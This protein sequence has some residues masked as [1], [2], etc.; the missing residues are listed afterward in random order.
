MTTTWPEVLGDLLAKRDLSAD[1]ARW[2][3]DQV[4][5]GEA[6][7]AQIAGFVIA[8]RAKGETAAEVS[9]LVAAMLEAAVT[10][11]VP[12]PSLDVVGTGGDRAHTVN[13][14]TMAALVAAGAGIPVVKH[15]N[16]AASSKTGTA[17]VLE[18]LGVAISLPPEAVRRCTLEAGIGFCFAA[19]FHPAMR[20]AGPTRRELGVPTVFNV[21]GPLANPAAPESALI[22]CAD[23]RLAP[24]LA[25]VLAARGTRAF[26]VRGEDGLDEITTAGPTRVW[27]ATGP[28]V[29]EQ[30]FD[31]GDLGIPVPA[32]GALRGDDAGFNAAVLR[33]VLNGE[34]GGNLGAVRDAV[35]LNAAA[36]IVAFDAV[37]GSTTYGGAEVSLSERFARALP[38]ATA[39]VDSGAAVAVLE[40]WI[41][42]SQTLAG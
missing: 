30:R 35:L 27:D 14:S 7:S 16:R 10:F 33:A 34:T 15:G 5:A 12:E 11:R 37:G 31:A 6:T 39:A 40:R 36:A 20:H 28:D 26:V 17:D 22:G 19:S 3:M 13:I 24:V 29:V 9:G 42:L 38:V 18:E 1:R 21:L 4:M 25:Q 32:E 41:V 23:A 2:A 8:L